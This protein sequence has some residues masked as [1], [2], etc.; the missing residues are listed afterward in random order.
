MET[1]GPRVMFWRHGCIESVCLKTLSE[2]TY[3]F[4]TATWFADTCS[5]KRRQLG[6]VHEAPQDYSPRGVHFQRW[7]GIGIEPTFPRGIPDRPFGRWPIMENRAWAHRGRSSVGLSSWK[8]GRR[9]IMENRAW[10][11]HGNKNGG[12]SPERRSAFAL[13]ALLI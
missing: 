4:Y 1:T 9:P 8:V 7:I 5:C 3:T 2:G 12:V 13:P 11:H 10:A 6:L